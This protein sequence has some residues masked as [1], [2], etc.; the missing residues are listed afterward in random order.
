MDNYASHVD[1]FQIM[2]IAGGSG[3]FTLCDD[4]VN[5]SGTKINIPPAALAVFNDSISKS[6]K[7][8]MASLFNPANERE[9]YNFC[10][11]SGPTDI[12][13]KGKMEITVVLTRNVE[14]NSEFKE[15]K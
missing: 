14:K 11:T 15:V 2:G 7:L 10:Y 9:V 8:D 4:P 5:E 1:L 12:C 6:G 3:S 13:I